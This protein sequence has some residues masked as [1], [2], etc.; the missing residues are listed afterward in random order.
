MARVMNFNPGPATLP[1]AALERAR[2][3][4]LDF[5]RTGMSVMEHSHRGSTFVKVHEEAIALLRGLLGIS[6][7]YQVLFLQGGARQQFALVPMNLRLPGQ[8]ADYVVT[9][10]WSEGAVEEAKKLGETRIAATT[11]EADGKFRRIP[12]AEELSFDPN[13]A[14]AH[15]TTNNTLYGTQWHAVPDAGAVP[16]VADASSDILCR[17]LDVSRFGLIYAGAQKNLGPSG[18]TVV[19]VRKDLMA[20]VPANVPSIFSY[21]V[22]A[23]DN[24]LYNTPPTFGIYLLRNVLSWIESEGGAPAMERRNTE[25]AALLYALL[26]ERSEFYRCP[27][28]RESRSLMNVCFTL[29]TPELDARFVAEA[30]KAGMVGL[31]GHRVTGGIRASLYNAVPLAWV[32]ALVEFMREFERT[33]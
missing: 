33:A 13:A 29:P 12:K 21:K 2:E 4:L 22:H 6:D 14:Y 3:E 7:D 26:D 25:K 30:T 8:S 9:G 11:K 23:K 27:V 17:P 10:G 28:E 5:E 16:L 31:K 15:I 24:S 18:V 19:I 1:L 20:R 32:Q